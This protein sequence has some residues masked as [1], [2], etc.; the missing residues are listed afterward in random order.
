ML[1]LPT[2]LLRLA[3]LAPLACGPAASP[4]TTPT[5][6]AMPADAAEEK[7]RLYTGPCAAK[8]YPMTIQF[9]AFVR[10]DGKTL[11][12]PAGHTLEG[13]WGR[14][15][16]A[17]VVGD[18]F[19]PVPLSLEILYFSYLEDTF[20]EG[21]FAL[22]HERLRQLLRTGF[23]G[24][25]E[26][27]Q[28]TYNQLMVCVLP[29]GMVVVWLSG[30]GR[31]VL[32]GRYQGMA[33]AVDFRRFYAKADRAEMFRYTLAEAPPAVQAQVRGGTLSTKQWD[34]YLKTYSWQ[35]A[36][37]Q[38]LRLTTY[39]V[40]FLSGEYVGEPETQDLAPYLRE[41]LTP[42]ARPVPQKLWLYVTDEAGHKY[43][44]KVDPMDE[45][46]TQA[47]FQQLHKAHPAASITLHVETD[48]YVKAATLV[49]ESGGQRIP[50][51]KSPVRITALN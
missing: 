10:P 25:R 15:N 27:Q 38:P 4:P 30:P 23:W 14:S 43:S 50:L 19:Q 47:A 8:G 17:Q 5:T 22:P 34:E 1:L 29:K 41:L 36:F 12:V 49:L 6:P 40:N 35:V 48:K 11:P 26:R 7:F 2:W 37:S 31:R 33:S 16:Y 39:Q 45:S 18:E 51:T 21:T 42:Q 44:L 32:V 13:S 24:Q 20:Y 28:L 46:E 3:L 9:G